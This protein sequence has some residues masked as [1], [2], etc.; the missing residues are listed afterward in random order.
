MFQLAILLLEHL[1]EALPFGDV[2]CRSK[3]PLERPVTVVERGRVV[4]HDGPRVVPGL[5]GEL[6]VSDG[7]LGQ[8][9]LDAG[10]GPVRIRK[11]SLNG[12]PISSS[13]V[14]PVNASICRLTSVMIPRGSVV[15]NASTLDSMSERV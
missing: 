15:I 5:R 10:P 9:P 6:V 11:L 14:Q 1:L 13:R 2:A 8:H 3:H 4:G 7:A 12:E